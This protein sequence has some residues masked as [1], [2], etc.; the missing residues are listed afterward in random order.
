MPTVSELKAQAKQRGLKGYS[1]MK[2]ADLEKLLS[3]ASAPKPRTLKKGF[4]IRRL[5]KS[6]EP[7]AL[8]PPPSMVG[9]KARKPRGL[10]GLVP[11]NLKNTKKGAEYLLS[12]IPDTSR[13]D[14]YKFDIE[15][16]GKNGQI[17]FYGNG[18]DR[19]KI[20]LDRVGNTLAQ[21]KKKDVDSDGLF[22]LDEVQKT[23]RMVSGL[24]YLNE[25][26]RDK[27]KEFLLSKN[28]SLVG[29]PI[30][31]SSKSNKSFSIKND[32]VVASWNGYAPPLYFKDNKYISNAPDSLY[33]KKD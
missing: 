5:P 1:T 32:A 27:V 16:G 18:V 20:N 23:A 2:K 21:I 22:N 15:R 6:N 9:K 3:G 8:P 7:I 13:R 24:S 10:K 31:P 4:G 11:S 33:V 19:F 28:P 26:Q 29:N 12:L 25:L 17:D 14:K 30:D